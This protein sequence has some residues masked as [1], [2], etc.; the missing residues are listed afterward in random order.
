LLHCNTS[1][2]AGGGYLAPAYQQPTMVECHLQPFT[3]FKKFNNWN[4]CSTHGGDIHHTHTSGTCCHPSPLHNLSATRTNT[5]GGL[6]AGLHK[7][8]LPSIVGHA[9]PPLRQQGAPARAMWQ[10]PP[11][12]MNITSL[13]A[14]MRPMMP[15]MPPVPYQVLY[16]VSQQFG[17]N[18][19]AAAPP[20]P[21]VPQPGT[22]IM[23]YYAQ[24]Q[25]PP[26]L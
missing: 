12:P 20:A 13:M 14:V 4:Y 26:P 5:M 10:Q 3:P 25:Q 8:V 6:T 18:P 23:P 15:M 24:Y 7:T 19:P 9:T 16:H 22:L 21:P 17:P 11:P 2:G 1:G